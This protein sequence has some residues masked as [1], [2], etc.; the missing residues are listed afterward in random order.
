MRGIS[1]IAGA[2]L[3]SEGLYSMELVLCTVVYRKGSYC[4][5]GGGGGGY[6]LDDFR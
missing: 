1:G 5:A 3:A 4:G 2:M 6:N